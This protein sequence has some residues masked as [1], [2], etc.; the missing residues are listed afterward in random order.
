MTHLVLT[1]TIC[2]RKKNVTSANNFI[3][4]FTNKR[5]FRLKLNLFLGFFIVTI[6]L[7]YPRN[8]SKSAYIV[9]RNVYI[10]HLNCR[11]IV[12]SR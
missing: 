7:F 5:K 12:K 9:Y 4:L 1:I 10:G 6:K 8:E 3:V 2:S 11:C